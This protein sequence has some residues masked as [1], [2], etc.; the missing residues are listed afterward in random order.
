MRAYLGTRLFRVAGRSVYGGV[1]GQ[2]SPLVSLLFVLG[3]VLPFV[4]ALRPR[5]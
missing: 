3:F 4:L 1:S 2:L 5:Q